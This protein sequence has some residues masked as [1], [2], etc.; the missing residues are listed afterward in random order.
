VVT[1]KKHKKFLHPNLPGLFTSAPKPKSR[2]LSTPHEQALETARG[3]LLFATLIFAVAYM[4]IAGGLGYRTLA[5]DAPEIPMAN[6]QPNGA[7]VARADITDRNG[8]VLATSLPTS[9]LCA[10]AKK[11]T[12]PDAVAAQLIGALPDLDSTKLKDDLHDTRHANNHCI[13]IKRHLTPRQYYE[14]NKLGIVGLEFLPD[15]R[16]IYPEENIAAHVVGYTDIDNNGLAGIEKK[17]DERLTDKSDPLA[18]SIDLRLQNIM[19]RELAVAKDSFHA[20]G[21]AGL[22]MDVS[23]GEILSMVSLPDFDPQHPGNPSDDAHMNRDTLGVYE[24]GSTF[25]IFNTALALDSG[26]IHLGDTFDTIDPI[27]VGGQAIRDFEP[28]KRWLNVAEI[29]THSSNIGAAHMAERVGSTKQR[30]LLTR[31]GLLDKEPLELPEVGSPLV[32]SQRE[33]GDAVTM[34]VAFGHGIAVN[35][36]QLASAV[37]TVVNNGVPVHPT[38]LMKTKAE[39]PEQPVISARA[40][41]MMR[42]LMRL[43]VTRGTAKGAEVA[44]YMMGGKTGTAEKL[45]PN[46]HYSPTARMSSF[47][48]VFPMNAPKYLVLAILDEP[49]GN[50]KTAGFATGG[51]VAAPVVSRVVAQMGPLMQIA[52]MPPDMEATAERQLL[53]PLGAQLLDGMPI[54]EGSNYA[55]V[56]DDSV[57]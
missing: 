54:E 52:P 11:I 23:T 16:R 20:V 10:D 55:S 1:H 28:E 13:A 51:W 57:R 46:H 22:I 47:V 39:N 35:A 42:G 24:M 3:R 50:A 18:L 15:E 12:D 53:K 7:V 38:L 40:S 27:E 4:G 33:W 41:A 21:A 37:S 6:T 36:V 32:P 30:A 31:L 26:S 49:K 44:G 29:F 56:E 17:F 8:V 2:R 9:S 43:V 5:N 45:L 34:T 14:V 19:H 25:K 48:G